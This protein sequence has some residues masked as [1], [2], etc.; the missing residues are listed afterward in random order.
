MKTLFLALLLSAML[1]EQS[2]SDEDAETPI[3]YVAV[4][5]VVTFVVFLVKKLK[6]SEPSNVSGHTEH[7]ELM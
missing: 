3:Y 2:S 6:T 5:L 7:E 4:F 1:F